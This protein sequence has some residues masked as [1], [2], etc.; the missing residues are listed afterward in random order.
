[1]SDW[2]LKKVSPDRFYRIQVD[3][4]GT[5]LN[6]GPRYRT[7]ALAR[8]WVSFVKAAWHGLPM[9]VVGEDEA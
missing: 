1:M 5:W 2:K 3:R 8:G 9:R 7:K 4:F 6:I